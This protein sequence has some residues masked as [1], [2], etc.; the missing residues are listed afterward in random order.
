MEYL[1]KLVNTHGL[2]GEVK[3]ISDFK[4]KDI[5]FK[6]GNTI[7]IELELGNPPQKIPALLFS[8]EFG[9]FIINKNK[10]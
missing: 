10:R 1:G 9:I 7:Y 8:E 6:E 2:R 5:I 3:I 4:Y